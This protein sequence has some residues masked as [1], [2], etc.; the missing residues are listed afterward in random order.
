MFVTLNEATQDTQHG[1]ETTVPLTGAS[2][3]RSKQ[4]LGIPCHD[5]HPAP[6]AL[7]YTKVHL[8][9]PPPSA[10]RGLQASTRSLLGLGHQLV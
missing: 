10:Q 5:K 6:Q 8:A 4:D 7:L 3:G 1:E 2:L 9:R